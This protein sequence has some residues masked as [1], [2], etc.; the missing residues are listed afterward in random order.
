MCEECEQAVP[1]RDVY[2]ARRA[3]MA[4]TWHPNVPLPS[5]RWI[6]DAPAAPASAPPGAD[7]RPTLVAAE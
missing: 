5:A 2:L 4:R 7:T 3:R 1:L 6:A